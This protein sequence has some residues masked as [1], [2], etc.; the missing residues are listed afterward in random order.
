MVERIGYFQA[1]IKEVGYSVRAVDVALAILYWA[2][3]NDNTEVSNH[4]N[5][6]R[7]IVLPTVLLKVQL[8]TFLLELIPVEDL[9][10]DE[11]DMLREIAIDLGLE[12]LATLILTRYYALSTS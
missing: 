8:V 2:S 1:A 5:Y 6:T 11:A 7:S 10:G 4:R 12:H 3:E 9:L